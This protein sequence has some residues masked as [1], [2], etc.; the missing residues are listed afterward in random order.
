M[1]SCLNTCIHIAFIYMSSY[2]KVIRVENNFGERKIASPAKNIGHSRSPH[3]RN[4]RSFP[5]TWCWSSL[6]SLLTMLTSIHDFFIVEGS[7]R[8]FMK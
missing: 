2:K 4:R 7:D 1:Y 8:L 6:S 3:V 5:R